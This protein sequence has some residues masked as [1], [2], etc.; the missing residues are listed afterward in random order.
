MYLAFVVLVFVFPGVP[1][2]QFNFGDQIFY[3]GDDSHFATQARHSVNLV[4]ISR[5]AR[6]L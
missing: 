4:S 6:A 3:T 1:G 5:V 2:V